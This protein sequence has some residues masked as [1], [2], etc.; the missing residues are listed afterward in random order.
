MQKFKKEKSTLK[1]Q[2][3]K[4]LYSLDRDIE[5][6]IMWYI[7]VVRMLKYIAFWEGNMAITMDIKNTYSFLFNTSIPRNLS[8]T[9]M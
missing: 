1:K 2:W 3:D 5:K 6:R 8:I 4:T 9:E 7:L